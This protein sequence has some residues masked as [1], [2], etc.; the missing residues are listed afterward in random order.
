MTHSCLSLI[1]ATGL[2]VVEGPFAR[3][4]DFLNML[5]TLRPDGVEVERSSTGTSIGAALLLCEAPKDNTAARIAPTKQDAMEA[6]AKAWAD[7]VTSA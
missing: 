3:N 2:T 5:A 6:Y 7:Q 4:K 1:G